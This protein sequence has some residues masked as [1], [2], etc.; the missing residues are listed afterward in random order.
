MLTNSSI[1]DY[2]ANE[3]VR[4]LGTNNA[5]NCPLSKNN[6]PFI[7]TNEDQHNLFLFTYN[8]LHVLRTTTTW[9]Q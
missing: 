8:T 1:A 6:E 5:G 7:G 3:N 4:K 2:S 9:S